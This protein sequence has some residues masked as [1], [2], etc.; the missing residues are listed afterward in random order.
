MDQLKERILRRDV[1]PRIKSNRALVQDDDKITQMLRIADGSLRI[2][3]RPGYG[4]HSGPGFR[5]SDVDRLIADLES[6]PAFKAFDSG[7]HQEA[8]PLDR[9]KRVNALASRQ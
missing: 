4:P 5:R 9:L 3:I 2:F 8:S 1:L 6:R 7:D